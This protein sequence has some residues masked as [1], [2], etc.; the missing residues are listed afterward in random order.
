MS[1]NHNLDSITKSQNKFLIG[2]V[3]IISL[4]VTQ[5]G[6]IGAV[7]DKCRPLVSCARQ[8]SLYDPPVSEASYRLVC[9]L[10]NVR[11]CKRGGCLVMFGFSQPVYPKAFTQEIM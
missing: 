3:N 7:F 4:E 11:G 2:D 10:I 8:Q 5:R 9:S 1:L 6:G